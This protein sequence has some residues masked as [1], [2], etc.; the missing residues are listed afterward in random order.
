MIKR[1]LFFLTYFFTAYLL[2]AMAFT[3]FFCVATCHAKKPVF[4]SPTPHTAYM[5]GD[6]VQVSVAVP[7]FAPETG[8]YWSLVFLYHPDST[9]INMRML[10]DSLTFTGDTDVTWTGRF[11]LPELRTGISQCEFALMEHPSL[12]IYATPAIQ[13]IVPYKNLSPKKNYPSKKPG[14]KVGMMK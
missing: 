12:S 6:S 8:K 14:T 1:I 3:V 2:T 5:H 13:I 9:S 4:L 10:V 7:R 11:L